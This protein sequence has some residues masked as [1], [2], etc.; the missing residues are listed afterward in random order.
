MACGTCGG[1]LIRKSR[2]KLFAVGV[3]ML[4]GAIA[5][6]RLTPILRTG[7]IFLVSGGLYL[8]VWST[9]GK[10]LWCRQCKKFQINLG[11][12]GR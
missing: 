1:E 10:G 5:S 12:P 11:R 2:V 3:A 6:F 7:S 8:L 9:W 4:A